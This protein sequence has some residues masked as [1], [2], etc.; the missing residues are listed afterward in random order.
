ME[1]ATKKAKAWIIILIC[2]VAAVLVAVPFVRA[3]FYWGDEPVFMGNPGM[4]QLIYH[5]SDIVMLPEEREN[6]HATL[7]YATYNGNTYAATFD[8]GFSMRQDGLYIVSFAV[9]EAGTGYPFLTEGTETET[10]LNAIS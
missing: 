6:I 9:S 10:V 2:I 7:A 4:Q 5:G 1:K 8:L 3:R